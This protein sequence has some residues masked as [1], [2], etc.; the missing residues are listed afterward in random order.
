[1]IG[2]QEV[3]KMTELTLRYKIE[4][5]EVIQT[6]WGSDPDWF[7]MEE[8]GTKTTATN[9]TRQKYTNE[10]NNA[11]DSVEPEV[12]YNP[13]TETAVGKLHYDPDADEIYGKVE[14]Q[15]LSP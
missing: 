11:I 7:E 2:C 13:D 10:I 6:F 4:T 1:M 3:T 15:P 8:S 5:G 12:D 14:I 9:T